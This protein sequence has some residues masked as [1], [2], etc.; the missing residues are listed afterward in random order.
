M[1]TAQA[2]GE[3]GK[4]G[5]PP[6]GTKGVRIVVENIRRVSK[7]SRQKRPPNTFSNTCEKP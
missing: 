2:H 4:E 3:M 7:R 1:N 5:K 6:R